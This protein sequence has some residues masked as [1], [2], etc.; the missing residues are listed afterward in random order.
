MAFNF[1]KWF[2][3]KDASA[4]EADG[5]PESIDVRI[6][7]GITIATFLEP[8]SVEETKAVIRHIGDQGVYH[9]RVWDLSRIDFPFTIDELRELAYY[10]REKMGDASRIALV[11]K[12]AVGFGSSRAFATH[13]EG[14]D[15]AKSRVFKSFDEAM[16]WIRE[17]D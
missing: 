4:G 12:D 1:R 11:V 17:D 6:V 13:R 14:D 9:R 8:S 3:K 10:G 15:L 7:D 5:L 16:Q 2:S